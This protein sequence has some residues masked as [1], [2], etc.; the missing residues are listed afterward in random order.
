[1]LLLIDNYDSF[2]FNLQRYLTQLGQEVC[3]LRN[4][5]PQ[6]LEDLASEYTAIVISPGPKSPRDAGH[7]LQVV[8]KWSGHLPILG[9][10]LGHQVIFEAFGGTIVRAAKPV[11]GKSSTM[12]LLTSRLFEGIPS[13]SR[14]ARYHSLIGAADSLPDW[15][16]VIAWSADEREIMAVEHREHPTF[17]VQFH[18]ESILSGHGHLLLRNFLHVAGQPDVGPLPKPDLSDPEQANWQAP[19]EAE[20]LAQPVVLPRSPGG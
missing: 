13:E 15:L 20:T 1:M 11:H 19:G 16:K 5:A 18:P 12:H 10:C 2:V 4:D 9:V 8:R 6:L 3:V 14:F 17:G 7:C